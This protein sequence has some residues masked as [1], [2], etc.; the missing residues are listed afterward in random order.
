LNYIPFAALPEPS[1]ANTKAEVRPLVVDH[2]IVQLPSASVLVSLRRR[3]EDRPRPTRGI[4]VIA[5]PV[6]EQDDP[7]VINR[8]KDTGFQT[9]VESA[10]TRDVARSLTIE[11]Q[12][13][14][15]DEPL[16]LPR[17]YSAHKEAT[18]ILSLLP[19][20]QGFS[21]LGF[22]A[23]RD[24][25][26]S[27]RLGSYNVIHFATHGLVNNEYPELSGIVLSMVNQHGQAENGV[28]QLH[29]VYNLKLSADLIVLSSCNTALG[30]NFPGEG[31]IGLT[32]GFLASGAQSVVASLWKVDDEA[33]ADLMGS[34]YDGML[35]DGLKPATALRK[36]QLEMW[37]KN[38]WH[39]PF[40]WAA[41]TLQG[42][43]D[44]AISI[45]P[46]NA[47]R[48]WNKLAI[49]LLAGGI[50]LVVFFCINFNLRS[51]RTNMKS[52]PN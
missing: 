51:I 43:W 50:A 12:L 8:T 15:M 40:F 22:N 17:L 6:F 14:N 25:V 24:L 38:R 49:I 42:D 45:Q 27:N 37:Q 20:K 47:D 29:D 41:F 1:P 28:L 30:K 10:A 9:E 52:A 2:E 35:K 7:R 21:A 33:T 34:F 36:A 26:I 4:A 31:L 23:T 32:Q 48:S 16:R 3:K 13:S 44:Q 5:D 18:E 39:A 19:A 11:P 46:R